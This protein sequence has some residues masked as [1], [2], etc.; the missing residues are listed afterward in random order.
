MRLIARGDEADAD[1]RAPPGTYAKSARILRLV[2]VLSL[3][4]FFFA[5]SFLPPYIPPPPP[6]KKKSKVKDAERGTRH[7]A[8][9]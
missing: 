5:L 8:T 2:R 3:S 4:V 7:A 9:L 6:Q 1:Q